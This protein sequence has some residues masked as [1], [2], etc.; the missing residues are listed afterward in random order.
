MEEGRA[1]PAR[2]PGVAAGGPRRRARGLPE[3]AARHRPRAAR[4]DAAG[5]HHGAR[6]RG[7]P[8]PR[9]ARRDARLG[10]SPL[11]HRDEHRGARAGGAPDAPPGPDGRGPAGVQ[12]VDRGRPLGVP[13]RARG[14]RPAL[15]PG[16]P[17]GP[18]LPRPRRGGGALLRYPAPGDAPAEHRRG[19]GPHRGPPARLR[20]GGARGAGSGGGG[21]RPGGAAR[22]VQRGA[23]LRWSRPG[24][25]R[26]L[27]C[28]GRA[29]A[30]HARARASSTSP[31]A[32]RGARR[33]WCARRRSARCSRRASRS[34]SGSATGPIGSRPGR[35]PGWMASGCSGQSKPRP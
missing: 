32:T 16:A 26:R 18:G 28:L 25:P 5:L 12:P 14:D 20:P 4:G 35:W 33:R 10:R 19:A 9:R 27:P 21:E 7:E 17:V 15:P 34:R 11:P 3:K 24:R 13:E 31:A 22:R 23:D 6:P 2:A 29:G 1:G 8:G 30:R